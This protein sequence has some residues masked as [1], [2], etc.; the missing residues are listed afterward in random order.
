MKFQPPLFNFGFHHEG[1][2]PDIAKD[3]KKE[4]WGKEFKV[5]ELYL[6]ATYEIAKQQ[7]KV[8]EDEQNNI[9]FWK[10]G[11]LVND[12]SDPIWLIYQLNPKK[13]K[14]KWLFKKVH[15]GNCPIVGRATDDFQIKI[16]PPEFQPNWTIHISQ[17]N[18]DHIYKDSENVVRLKSV[19]GEFA[20]NQ[21]MIF[22]TV[23]G[24]IELNR[25]AEIVI[26]QW[27]F[28][29]YQFLMPL[30]LTQPEKVE[31]AATLSPN[32]AMKRYEIRTLLLPHYS[33]AYARS[34]VKSRAAFANWMLLSEEE[35]N[36]VYSDEISEG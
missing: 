21:H 30:F 22:R 10:A 9:A 25:K 16:N 2:L 11:Y 5:L 29:D 12:M 4:P 17:S 13:D 26:P 35:L 23:L 15:S 19:F 32:P 27:Y 7:D 1:W 36:A 14:Q 34:L 3:L 24:E 6:R 28:N 18:I 8:Y 31:L 20:V 33:Y